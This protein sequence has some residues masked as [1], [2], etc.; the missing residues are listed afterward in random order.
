MERNHVGVHVPLPATFWHQHDGFFI[1]DCLYS[2]D[3]KKLFCLPPVGE[4]WVT[5]LSCHGITHVLSRG[6]MVI[7]LLTQCSV[8]LEAGRLGFKFLSLLPD[9]VTL[10]QLQNL[11]RLCFLTSKRAVVT[12]PPSMHLL[13]AWNWESLADTTA[14]ECLWGWGIGSGY[15]AERRGWTS[16]LQYG[17]F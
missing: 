16:G 15:L 13:W 8:V 5:F 3:K 17:T 7:D 12:P 9:C 14:P 11:L 6:Q 2:W 10:S 4:F 1:P